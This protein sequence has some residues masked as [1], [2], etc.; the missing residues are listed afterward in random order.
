MTKQQRLLWLFVWQVSFACRQVLMLPVGLLLVP[1]TVP[2]EINMLFCDPAVPANAVEMGMCA[3]GQW[4]SQ[5]SWFEAPV[6]T[7]MSQQHSTNACR[8]EKSHCLLV[9]AAPSSTQQIAVPQPDISSRPALPMA[10]LQ[11]RR[12]PVI[13]PSASLLPQ[14][15]RG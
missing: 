14:Y 3:G 8:T 4:L 6:A 2:A 11:P 15:V 1:N 13:H 7:S 5:V 10:G 12:V 9:A